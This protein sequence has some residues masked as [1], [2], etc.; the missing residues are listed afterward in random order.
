MKFKNIFKAALI[1][2]PF[3]VILNGCGGGGKGNGVGDG[4]NLFP[5][6]AQLASSTYSNAQEVEEML[7]SYNTSNNAPSLKVTSSSVKA[8]KNGSSL[9]T[10][11]L[12]QLKSVNK[13]LKKRVNKE[14]MRAQK[15]IDTQEDCSNGGTLLKDGELTKADGGTVQYD[16]N[17]CEIDGIE[18]DGIMDVTASNYDYDNEVF[19]KIKI[20]Y[21][22][23]FRVNA[24]DISY[25]IKRG[26]VV[27]S[28]LLDSGYLKVKSNIVSTEDGKTKGFR[29]V[30][31]LIDNIDESTIDLIQTQGRIYI[32]GLREYVNYNKNYD[33]SETP[34]EYINSSLKNG[35]AHYFMKDGLLKIIVEDG[36]VTLDY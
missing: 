32:N 5:S 34:F 15:V 31:F 2:I 35:E 7:V 19:T 10:L 13:I 6:D 21:V 23:D 27:E 24:G 8:K 36:V 20:D 3:V 14:T 12:K 1:V 33:M 25:K 16:F 17:H 9:A 30:V 28:E 26:S 29:D 4:G 18:Y 11:T 22:T